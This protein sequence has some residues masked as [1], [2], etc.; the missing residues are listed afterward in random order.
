MTVVDVTTCNLRF[1][2]AGQFDDTLP[3]SDQIQSGHGSGNPGRAP[4]DRVQHS[5][6]AHRDDPG[7]ERISNVGSKSA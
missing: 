5:G 2:F 7:Q 3:G 1:S 6:A 4:S